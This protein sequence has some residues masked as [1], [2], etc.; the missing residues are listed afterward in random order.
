MCAGIAAYRK[1]Y[2][3][4]YRSLSSAYPSV[5]I[6]PQSC[7]DNHPTLAAGVDPRR[8]LR[9]RE[10][11]AFEKGSTM[12]GRQLD[13]SYPLIKQGSIRAIGERI[14]RLSKSVSMPLFVGRLP[15]TVIAV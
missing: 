2:R 13:W 8:W 10:I 6:A 9:I 12:V 1:Q 3:K 15:P 7:A 14:Q 5:S 4:Q 11:L